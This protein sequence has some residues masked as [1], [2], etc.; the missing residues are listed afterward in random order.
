MPVVAKEIRQVRRD[1]FSLEHL[2]I[3]LDVAGIL[4][5]IFAGSEL[6]GIDEDRD[7]GGIARLPAHPHQSKMARVCSS[8]TLD[9]SV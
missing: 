9:G 7:D 6:S 4:F 2:A 5:K 3:P 1:P 8:G